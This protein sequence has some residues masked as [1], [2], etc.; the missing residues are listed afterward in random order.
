MIIHEE[1]YLDLLA[2]EMRSEAATLLLN[3]DEVSKWIQL[4]I[5]PDK[6]NL[7][8]LI[9]SLERINQAT[10]LTIMSLKE[11]IKGKQGLH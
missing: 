7:G 11:L 8:F 1:T 6:E 3:S 5:K 10:Q 4:D 2:E 9:S